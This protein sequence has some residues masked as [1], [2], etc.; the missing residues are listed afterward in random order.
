VIGLATFIVLSFNSYKIVT[1]RSDSDFIL[2]KEDT[3]A[4]KILLKRMISE[5]DQN[6]SKLRILIEKGGTSISSDALVGLVKFGDPD[7]EIPFLT[8]QIKKCRQG[9]KRGC[10]EMVLKNFESALD[11][12]KEKKNG[13]SIVEPTFV[14]L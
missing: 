12:F 14:N 5:G 8:Q 1:S 3:F 4:A 2:E 9:I 10:D 6:L 13:N 11:F 7:T